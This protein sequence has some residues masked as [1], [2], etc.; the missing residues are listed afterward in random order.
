MKH[1]YHDREDGLTHCKTCGG[2]EGSL[3]TECPGYRMTESE[4]DSVYAGKIDFL[5][6]RWVSARQPS[7]ANNPAP[8]SVSS[9]RR[10]VIE[11]KLLAA[12]E[13]EG[14]VAILANEE[15]LNDLIWVM[16][17]YIGGSRD[18]QDRMESMHADLSQLRDAAFPR[19][20]DVQPPM[21][22]ESQ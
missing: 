4:E 1:E 13:N 20:A 18:Q 7:Q 8:F 17:N 3:A 16:E 6:G 21:R 14:T 22:K 12:L 9:T 10:E 11:N 5:D 19:N 2:A 15:M